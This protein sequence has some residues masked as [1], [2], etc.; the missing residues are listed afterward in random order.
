MTLS[1]GILAA[2]SYTSLATYLKSLQYISQIYNTYFLPVLMLFWL[3][4]PR[5][6]WLNQVSAGAAEYE[7]AALRT[8]CSLSY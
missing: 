2:Y 8:T 6:I 7:Y 1:R 5:F 4:S 3:K